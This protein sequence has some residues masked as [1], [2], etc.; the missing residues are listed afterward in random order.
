MLRPAISAGTGRSPTTR[1]A[2]GIAQNV[3]PPLRRSGWKQGKQSSYLSSTF[4]WFL[5]FPRRLGRIALQNRREVYA[6]LFRA[7]AETLRPTP[8][9][10]S[11][12]V[13]RS[14]S[15]PSCTRGA[16]APAPST[17]ALRRTGRWARSRWLALDRMPARILLPVRVLSRVFRGKF[18]AQLRSAFDRGRFSFHGKLAL[19]V[20]VSHIW[21]G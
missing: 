10:P 14:D 7:A 4:M 1:A 20:L 18:L 8:P 21:R 19:L 2:T 13:P 15:W 17:C 3:R 9:I 5:R 11:T 16:I 12:S 6:L